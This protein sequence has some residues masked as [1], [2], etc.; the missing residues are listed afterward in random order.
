[1]CFMTAEKELSRKQSTLIS[2]RSVHRIA[3]DN[4]SPF[5]LHDIPIISLNCIYIYITLYIYIYITIYLYVYIHWIQLNPIKIHIIIPSSCW[6]YLWYLHHIH[7]YRHVADMI[8]PSPCSL[9]D[10]QNSDAQ[11]HLPSISAM[12]FAKFRRCDCRV[13]LKASWC[14]WAMANLSREDATE[15][16]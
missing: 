13:A 15:Q 8:S 16:T 6:W 3:L 7:S 2:P 14:R 4:P 11:F 5:Y 9:L 10:P 12:Y 1:M